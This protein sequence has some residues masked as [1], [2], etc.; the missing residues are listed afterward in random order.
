MLRRHESGVP[1]REI[2]PSIEVPAACRS[3]SGTAQSLILQGLSMVP[4]S[5]QP[6]GRRPAGDSVGQIRKWSSI[7]SRPGAFAFVTT[8]PSTTM[9]F[10]MF[11][12]A[13]ARRNDRAPVDMEI[14]R[15]RVRSLCR[16]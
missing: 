11:W 15:T 10:G 5:S 3:T 14:D 1:N 9:C 6:P 4:W 7:H 13:A 2:Q 8:G 12:P 16:I